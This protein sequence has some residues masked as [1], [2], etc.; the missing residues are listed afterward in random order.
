MW[1]EVLEA[2]EKTPFMLA[3][4]EAALSCVEAEAALSCMEA[5]TLSPGR[6]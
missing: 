3:E 1:G 2:A 6:S 4:A 5:E